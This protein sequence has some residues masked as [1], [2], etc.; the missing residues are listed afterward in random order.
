[1]EEAHPHTLNIKEISYTKY[2]GDTHTHTQN[3]RKQINYQTPWK[4]RVSTNLR[5]CP[6]HSG[7]KNNNNKKTKNCTFKE[8]F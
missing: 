1:M 5:N 8:V 6:R 3:K 4:Y 2:Q 7:M